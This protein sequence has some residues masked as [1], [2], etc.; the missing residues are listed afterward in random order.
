MYNI[1]LS[2]AEIPFEIPFRIKRDGVAIV[3][4]RS[5]EGIYAY[6]DAC[7]H[8]AWPLSSGQ[9]CDGVLECPG[10][11]WEFNI[12]TG[13]C[14]NAPV[15]RLTPVTVRVDG[16]SICFEYDPSTFRPGRRLTQ[17]ENLSAT[18]AQ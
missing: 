16:D 5:R 17:N 2:T 14:L 9:V 13:Q 6:E 8:A 1:K 4:Y 3:V 11:G 10:H 15:Y 12:H 7:P 18:E